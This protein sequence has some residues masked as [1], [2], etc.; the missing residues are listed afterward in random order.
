MLYG[1]GYAPCD[2]NLPTLKVAEENIIRSKAEYDAFAAKHP[3]FV[4]GAADSQ[5]AACCDSEPILN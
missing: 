3:L 5:C 1:K 4:V 2:E